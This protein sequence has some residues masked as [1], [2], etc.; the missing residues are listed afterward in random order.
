VQNSNIV[1]EVEMHGLPLIVER[2]DTGLYNIVHGGVLRHPGLTAENAIGAMAHYV[3]S[4]SYSLG[5]AEAEL[6]GKA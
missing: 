2:L 4:L 3:H 5:K 6:S 1:A